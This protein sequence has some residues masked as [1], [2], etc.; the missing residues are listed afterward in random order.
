MKLIPHAPAEK[1]AQTN[2]TIHTDIMF[3]HGIAFLLSIAKP[4]GLTQ[5]TFLNGSRTLRV[6]RRALETQIRML[7]TQGFVVKTTKCDPEKGFEAL[8]G[9]FPGVE[10]IIAGP[11]S[12]E[13]VAERRIQTIKERLRAGEA[14]LPYKLPPTLIDKFILQLR[15]GETLEFAPVCGGLYAYLD[16]SPT[17]FV[18]VTVTDNES[19]YTHSPR[20]Q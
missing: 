6:I 2:Q 20:G 4:L 15:N 10:M 11:G 1:M 13:E 8:V 14:G 17:S 19:D 9:A 7:R 18:S 12:H 5:A 16:E 3:W